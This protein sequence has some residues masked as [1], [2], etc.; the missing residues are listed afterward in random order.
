RL[1]GEINAGTYD[2]RKAAKDP[3]QSVPI[4]AEADPAGIKRRE[5]VA[6]AYIVKAEDGSVTQIVLPI[7]GKG[8]WSTLY[9][10]LALR[11]DAG[12][13]FPVQGITFYEHGETPGL[14]GEVDNPRWKS[15]WPG[16]LLLN[17]AGIPILQVTKPDR[18]AAD[19]EIDGISGASITSHGVEH[20]VNYWLG[21]DGFG[22][23][24]ERLR[25]GEIDLAAIRPQR[26]RSTLFAGRFR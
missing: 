17:D 14:G 8:L 1:N 11:A 5:R 2:P 26:E 16:K 20:L 4:P 7:Y 25:R 15:Q 21:E 3:Q 10:F 23:F 24:L 9:G 19:N 18:A 22:P 12:A 13:G 6:A